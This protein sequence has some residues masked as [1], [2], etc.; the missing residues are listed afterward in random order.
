MDQYL[1]TPGPVP[2][3]EFV[4]RAINKPVIHHRTKEF[5][6]FYQQFLQKL[7]YLF[8]AE[9]ESAAVGTMIGSGTYGVETAIYSIFNKQETVL[10][11]DNGK[12]SKRWADYG[13]LLG[14]ECGSFADRMGKSTEG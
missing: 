10:V 7:R 4:L 1:L 9:S 11:P 2:V 8:Q 6:Q 12:F 14:F 5:L 3:P 13:R